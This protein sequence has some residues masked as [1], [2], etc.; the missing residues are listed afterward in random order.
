[1]KSV[2]KDP[3]ALTDLERQDLKSAMVTDL[4]P[5]KEFRSFTCCN[6]KNSFILLQDWTSLLKFY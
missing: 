4:Y 2:G 5:G 6:R 1:M 3:D